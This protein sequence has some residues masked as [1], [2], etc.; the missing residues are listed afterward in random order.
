M[1][2]HSPPQPFVFLPYCTFPLPF[3]LSNLWGHIGAGGDLFCYKVAHPVTVFEY[4]PIINEKGKHVQLTVDTKWEGNRLAPVHPPTH[5]FAWKKGYRSDAFPVNVTGFSRQDLSDR[6]DACPPGPPTFCLLS[7]FAG[8]FLTKTDPTVIFRQK[9]NELEGLTR[10]WRTY[11]FW[12]F[13][14]RRLQESGQ[15]LGGWDTSTWNVNFD[16]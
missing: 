13:W 16:L 12:E 11:R 14:G 2:F 3:I 10:N 8:N 7:V 15:G 9:R 6:P 4:A 5:P 1:V